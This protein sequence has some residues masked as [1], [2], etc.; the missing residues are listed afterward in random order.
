MDG[1][2]PHQLSGGQRQRIA[3]AG[4]L[5]LGPALAVTAEPTSMLDVS[6]RVG[7]MNTLRKDLGIGYLY[8]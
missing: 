4:A 5:I 7:V 1:L 6:V 8:S 3:I 2:H